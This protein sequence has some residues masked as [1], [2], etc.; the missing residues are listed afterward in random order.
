MPRSGMCLVTTTRWL[1]LGVGPMLLVGL[2]YFVAGPKTGSSSSR[3]I[4]SLPPRLSQD[5]GL[6]AACQRAAEHYRTLLPRDWNYVVRPPYLLGGDLPA[7][8]LEDVYRHTLAPTARALGVEY[9]DRSPTEPIAILLL[10]SDDSY[11]RCT[12]FLGHGDRDEYAGIYVRAERRLV[13]N[14]STGAGTVAHELTHALAHVDFPEMPQWFD[15]GL[16][17]LH[18]ECQFSD[19]GLRLIGSPNWRGNLLRQAS[20]AHRLPS[21]E[22]FVTKRFGASANAPLD[23]AQARYLCLFLQERRLLGPFYR[24]CRANVAVDPTGGWSLAAVLGHDDIDAVDAEF[25]AWLSATK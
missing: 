8:D 22:E 23:Y 4:A 7:S 11:R 16:A 21:L 6:A 5:D 15:E 25:R 1:T 24:K 18:E 3:E 2:C 10:S 19:D 13:L 17:S 9:F 20:D 12:E 14:Y